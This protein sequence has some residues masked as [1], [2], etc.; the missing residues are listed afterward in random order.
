[1]SLFTTETY[2]DPQFKSMEEVAAA[3]DLWDATTAS[4]VAQCPRMAEEKI[5]YGLQSKTESAAKTAGKT[6]HAGLDLY[7]MGLD[8][9]LCLEAAREAWKYGPDHRFPSTHK[10]AH[11]HQ[12]HFE[13]I[14]KNYF[15]F[16]ARRDSFKPLLVRRDAINLK[17]VIA[18]I[19]QV[20]EEGYVILG[21]SK[22]IMRFEVKH[23]KTG[24][25]VEVTHAGR[26]DL[27]ITMGGLNYVLD[28][29]STNSYL[30]DWF[31]DKFK[32]SNQFRGYCKMVGELTGLEMAG[33]LINGI[34]M[35][36]SAA[37]VGFKGNRF[38]RFG[39]LHYSQAQLDECLLNQDA[40]KKT[41]YYYNEQGYFPQNAP[42]EGCKNCDFA[43]LC[44]ANPTMRNAIR[45]TEY[46]VSE[47]SVFETF[48]TL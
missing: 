13:V 20:T 14:L 39:P 32:F 34:Y 12:G 26:P 3:V 31:F 30:S 47:K 1:M 35:G 2:I 24:K 6:L 5:L 43:Q 21:E 18:G 9:E 36:K 19:W 28:H 11:M 41:L 17:N 23:P 15:D 40:W 33:A 29:K 22:F 8:R 46:I 45:R 27:P 10:Y 7:Y 38:A 48:L 42:S 44:S 25:L 37:E 4:W 16:A